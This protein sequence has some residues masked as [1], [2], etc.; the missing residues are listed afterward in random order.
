MRYGANAS[1]GESE[2]LSPAK[3]SAASRRRAS[4]ASGTGYPALAANS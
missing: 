1:Y 4:T 2:T 3:L